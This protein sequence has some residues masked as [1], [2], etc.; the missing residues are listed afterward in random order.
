LEKETRWKHAKRNVDA[1]SYEELCTHQCEQ[2]GDGAMHKREWFIPA[3][4]SIVL[5]GGIAG[6]MMAV[7]D[8]GSGRA[9]QQSQLGDQREELLDNAC[10][11][12]QENTGVAID[13]E[14]LAEGF[15]LSCRGCSS[16][17]PSG[18]APIR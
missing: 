10:A 6:G 2:G 5:I 15:G 18:I 16:S 3:V 12:Y 4:L 9:D 1:E 7:A 13:S 17:D 14:E 11:T 8:D